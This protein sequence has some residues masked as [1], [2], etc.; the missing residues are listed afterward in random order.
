MHCDFFKKKFFSPLTL[1]L[2]SLFQFCLGGERPSGPGVDFR[3][4]QS[5]A[6]EAANSV[7]QH[8]S[9]FEID[10]GACYSFCVAPERPTAAWIGSLSLVFYVIYFNFFTSTLFLF[11]FICYYIYSACWYILRFVSILAK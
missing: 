9:N 7:H 10:F 1:S 11:S 5:Q 6:H 8:R 4:R 3:A 2:F